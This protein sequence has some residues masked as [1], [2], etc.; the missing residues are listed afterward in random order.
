MNGG[1]QQNF[2]VVPEEIGT[3]HEFNPKIPEITLKKLDVDELNF[4]NPWK[5][6]LGGKPERHK[7]MD[8]KFV[9]PT[10][11]AGAN[12]KFQ[13]FRT[14]SSAELLN[15]GY[16]AADLDE[17]VAASTDF[18]AALVAT[19]NARVVYRNK[20]GEKDEIKRSST[21]TIR[22]WA[23]RVKTN[24]LATPDILAKFGIEPATPQAGPVIPPTEL[25]AQPFADGSCVLKWNPSGNVYGTNYILEYSVEPGVWAWLGSTTKRTYVDEFA[26]PGVARFYRVRAQRAGET[27][28]PGSETS[29][30]G[31][32]GSGS[33]FLGVAA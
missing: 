16:D 33:G 27:S 6:S 14:G 4:G 3:E 11:D 17:V 28:L 20:V 7:T 22:L 30:Y 24:P 13:Q 10:T 1:I 31:N 5:K 32:E 18:N 12:A 2:A 29:I 23:N 9:I 8:Y 21:E 15:L 19:E 26:E 25:S